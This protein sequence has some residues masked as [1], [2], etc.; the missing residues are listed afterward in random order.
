MNYPNLYDISWKVDEPTYR[1]DPALSYSTLARFDREGFDKLDHLYDRIET[2]SLTFGSAVDT[3]ITGSQEEFSDQFIIA[4]FPP[5][6]DNLQTIAKTLFSLYSN[7]HRTID[8]ID[9]EILAEVGANCDFYSNPKY[10]NYRVKLI[11]ENCQ[12]Y[13]NI[14]YAAQGKKILDSETAHKVS[15][16]VRALK[17]SPATSWYFMPDSPFNDAVQRFYQLKFKASF[18]DIDYRIMAD[19]IVVDHEN[20]EIIPVDLKTSSHTEWDFA[21][22]FVQWRYHIQ[23]RLYWRVLRK[24]LD[25]HPIFKDYTLKNYRFIVVNKET[26]TPLVWEFDKTQEDG[27]L[28]YGRNGQ[29]LFNDPFYLGKCLKYY[30]DRKPRVPIGIKLNDMNNLDNKLNEL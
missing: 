9:D 27:Q 5:I 11:K 16:V 23:A 14:M 24:N 19:L 6:S 15:V 18:D 3:L 20:K 26:V 8:S 10:K 17:E 29:I 1:E 25:A 22:S 30:L 7:E 28:E 4:E 2:P 12:D 21:S 13:Y